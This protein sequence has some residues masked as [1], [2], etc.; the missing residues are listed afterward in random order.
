MLMLEQYAGVVCAC[1]REGGGEQ[2]VLHL[3]MSEEL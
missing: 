2:G 3:Q 1:A